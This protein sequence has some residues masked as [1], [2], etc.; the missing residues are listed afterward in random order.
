MLMYRWTD[1]LKVVG[2]SDSDFAGCVDSRKSI[3]EYVFIFV[4][5]AVSWRSNK[6]TLTTTSIMEAEFVSCFE[7]TSHGVRLRSFMY[8]L[9]VID[10]VSRPLRM[11]CDNLVAVFRAKNNKSGC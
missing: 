5:G 3:S 6:Q 8:G 2:Y 9:R 7:A 11:F 1:N 4:S 10:S